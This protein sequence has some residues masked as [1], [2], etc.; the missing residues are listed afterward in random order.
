[1]KKGISISFIAFV[2]IAVLSAASCNAK[3]DGTPAASM[4]TLYQTNGRPVNGR[5]LKLEDFSTYRKY[6]TVLSASSESTAYSIVTDVVRKIN[7]KVGDQVAK[8]DIVVSFSEDNQTYRQALL[9]YESAQSSFARIQALYNDADVS[10]QD[11]EN[12][13]T[14]NDLAKARLDA[15]KDLVFVRSPIAGT[16]TSIDVHLTENVRPGTPLF[17]VSSSAAEDAGFEGV[18]YVGSDEIGEIK[19]GA[20][21]FID[22]EPRVEGRVIQVSLI[23]DSAR[24]SFPVRAFFPI[25]SQ[26][27]KSGLVSGM[28]LDLEVETY[29]NEKAIVVFRQELV[30]TDTGYTAFISVNNAATSVTVQ[31]GHEQGLQYEITSGLKEGDILITQGAQPLSDGMKVKVQTDSAAAK[32]Q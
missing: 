21:V 26:E 25:T 8:D 7:R 2:C 6:A 30:K 1:M 4:E 28:A 29:R 15:A 19:N 20:R 5:Q 31:T 24:Q 32:A 13:K 17:T 18:F 12:A 14:Q 10:K 3:K 23:M 16:V 9:G 27:E 11:Y 22:R